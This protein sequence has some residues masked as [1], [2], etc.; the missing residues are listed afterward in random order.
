M[1]TKA[2]VISLQS[3]R[4]IILKSMRPNSERH[5]ANQAYYK[6]EKS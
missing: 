1:K 2:L 4:T 3:Y 6:L 5:H